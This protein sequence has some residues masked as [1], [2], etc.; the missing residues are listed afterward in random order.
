MYRLCGVAYTVSPSAAMLTG[1]PEPSEFCER[2]KVSTVRR[3]APEHD[4]GRRTDAHGTRAECVTPWSVT[5]IRGSHWLRAARAIAARF[6]SRRAVSPT[7]GLDSDGNAIRGTEPMTTCTVE[8]TCRA[9]M[10]F[11]SMA[12][13]PMTV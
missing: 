5:S 2:S 9:S 13:D 3:F 11:P 4:T 6:A 1:C 7:S 8:P 10:R 12:Y